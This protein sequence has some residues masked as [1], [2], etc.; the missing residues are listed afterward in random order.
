MPAPAPHQFDTVKANYAIVLQCVTDGVAKTAAALGVKGVTDKAAAAELEAI[1]AK[2]DADIFALH[3][4]DETPQDKLALLETAA[5]EAGVLLAVAAKGVAAAACHFTKDAMCE[6]LD[7]ELGDTITDHSV[8]D[9]HC[10]EF[11]RK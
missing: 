1:V 6:R 3:Q 8:F 4:L 11:E 10:K 9:A 2:L 7:D 5:R